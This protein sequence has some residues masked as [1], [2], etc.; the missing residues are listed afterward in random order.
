MHPPEFDQFAQDYKS[1]HKKNIAC[2]GEMP[3]YFAEYK[4]KDLLN[5]VSK[6]ID[7]DKNPTILDFGTGVGSSIP[8][9]CKYFPTAKI[10]GVDVSKKSLE[11]AFLSHAKRAEFICFDGKTLPF[12]DH[13]FDIIFTSCVFHHIPPSEHISM[14]SEIHR[15]LATTGLCMIYEHN[16]LNPLTVH[17]VNT[18]EFDEDAILINAGR[19]KKNIINAKFSSAKIKFRVFFPKI[20]SW[21]RWVEKYLTWL[22]LGAQYYILARK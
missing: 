16:P 3:E 5:A 20:F 4:I 1:L 8:Y 6:Q 18:C 22:P 10:I 9:L 17:A 21:L 15:V 14:L 2:T 13:T 12:A 11:F 19:M 7:A